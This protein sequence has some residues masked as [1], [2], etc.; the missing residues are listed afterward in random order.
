MGMPPFF[1]G[2]L[3]SASYEIKSR[4]IPENPGMAGVVF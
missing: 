3:E 1:G 4:K 2:L